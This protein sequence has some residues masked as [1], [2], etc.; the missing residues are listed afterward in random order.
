MRTASSGRR[1]NIE[2][3]GVSEGINA[4]DNGIR[5]AGEQRTDA[6]EQA[7]DFLGAPAIVLAI[8]DHDH[9]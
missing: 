1:N 7:T 6:N 5:P 2:E 4:I 3:A 9:R 8:T